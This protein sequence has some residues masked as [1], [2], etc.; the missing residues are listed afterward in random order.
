MIILEI[1]IISIMIIFIFYRIGILFK[2][3]L[4]LQQNSI[5]YIVL[6]GFIFTLS[7]FEII[8]LPFNILN[9][10][11]KILFFLELSI[12]LFFV[13]MSFLLKD[14]KEKIELNLKKIIKNK[15][16]N[17]IIIIVLIFISV[18]LQIFLSSY[19]YTT[20]ADDSFYVS[21]SREASDFKQYMTND[22]SIGLDN[23][24]FPKHYVF[25]SW[26]IFNGFISKIF[27][28]DVTVLV[29]TIYPIIFILLAY[30]AYYLLFTKINKK[31]SML[32]L[33]ILSIIF[34]FSGVSEKF[35][36]RML[37]SRVWQG[38]VILINILVPYLF[39]HLIDLKLSKK[40][41]VQ[42]MLLNIASLALNPIAMWII[43]IL[44]FF[45]TVIMLLK[46]YYKNVFKMLIVI[47]PNL[48]LLPIY[49]NL[50]IFNSHSSKTIIYSDYFDILKSFVGSGWG[51]IIIYIL[52]LV[53]IIFR[54]NKQIKII[55]L[56]IPLL[57]FLTL[58][59][60]FLSNYV[61]Q[62]ITSELVYWRLYWFLSFEITISYAFSDL[63]IRAKYMSLRML[64]LF[65]CLFCIIIC[66]KVV[67]K[68]SEFD[69]H[70][71]YEKI[72]KNIIEETKFIVHN[73]KSGCVVIGPN[74]LHSSTMRQI[75]SDIGLVF[76]RGNYVDFGSNQALYD[77]VYDGLEMFEIYEIFNN[78][79]VD[80][81]I[82]DYSNKERF[83]DLNIMKA[84]IVYE[85]KY[86]IIIANMNSD[87]VNTY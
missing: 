45:F 83:Y 74:P 29:H 60:P 1:F 39:L 11:V 81:I 46:K 26:E 17:Q 23:S 28:I 71:N 8:A 54:K 16:I 30:I 34:L 49:F 44:E 14:D 2:K 55:S 15:S 85:D 33:F 51:F 6:N 87:F 37:L 42:L 22:P 19:L 52:S 43:P 63:I 31:N 56:L 58:L 41:I 59:N 24:T 9:W 53:Y 47:I 75:T 69:K 36:G 32:A 13:I 62:Y 21:W 79:N 68:C 65:I 35:I 57:T 7:I 86:Y 38:K 73:S 84:K 50:V 5:S 64:L 66:G 72:P 82:V 80:Y 67:Y 27:N 76:S 4:K 40:K 61:Q 10:N 3:I 12:F 48:I 77:K 78:E 18:S 20:N 25:N 70:I